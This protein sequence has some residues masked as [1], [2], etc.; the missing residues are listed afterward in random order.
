[1]RHLWYRIY[2]CVLAIL[3]W[4]VYVD[5][6][7]QKTSACAHTERIKITKYIRYNKNFYLDQRSFNKKW[8]WKKHKCGNFATTSRLLIYIL[9]YSGVII[10]SITGT[11]YET[12]SLYRTDWWWNSVFSEKEKVGEWDGGT[13]GG[14]EC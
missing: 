12:S 8:N 6:S 9:V 4:N 11:R 5:K 10:F 7:M 1:M 14:R 2:F 3:Y 13:L